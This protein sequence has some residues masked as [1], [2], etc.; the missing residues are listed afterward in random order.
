MTEPE[1]RRRPRHRLLVNSGRSLRHV[2]AFVLGVMSVTVLTARAES[3]VIGPYLQN[4][5]PDAITVIWWTDFSTVGHPNRVE[6]GPGF[7]NTSDAVQSEEASFSAYAYRYKQQARLTGLTGNQEYSYRVRSDSSLDSYTSAAYTFHTAPGR[8]DDVHFAVMGDGRNDNQAIIDRHKMVFTKALSHGADFVLYGGDMVHYGSATAPAADEDW[9]QYLTEIMC[10]GGSQTGSGAG[11]LVPVYMAVGNHEIYRSGAGYDGGLT[12]SMARYMAI[13]DN[14]DN[15]SST[16]D[17]QERYFA[18]WYG[19]CYVICLDANN[20]SDDALD[21]HDFLA[22]GTTPDWEP[23]SEQYVWMTNQLDYAQ[24]NAALT[25][26]C[27]HPASYSRGVH[28]DPGDSQRGIEL[29]VLD[30]VFRQYGVDGVMV[31]HDHMV[32]RCVSGPAGFHT[33]YANGLANVLTWRDEDNLNYF[34]Q[35]NSGQSSRSAD[36][37]W[38]T[39]MDITGNNAAPFY[40][41]Y[42]YEWSGNDSYSSFTDVDVAWV[43]SSS[44]WR[45]TFQVV[46]TDAAGNTSTHDAFWIERAD[47]LGGPA[48]AEKSQGTRVYMGGTPRYSA[49]LVGL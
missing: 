31:S 13:C 45:A 26:V 24:Q 10:T 47:P 42:F 21:N 33:E 30:P 22:D 7:G 4:V 49:T 12:T 23:G 36:A 28:G 44:K 9:K 39:W 41:A 15:G 35:G 34:T 40:T 14:P 48:P 19:P 27:F 20:T 2:A 38:E 43:S 8:N 3:I 17:W 37:G 25:F 5:T 1:D 29:R 16:P 11:N 32:E 6:Y 46:R 18:F